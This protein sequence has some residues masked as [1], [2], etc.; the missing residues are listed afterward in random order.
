MV[1]YDRYIEFVLNILDERG[2]VTREDCFSLDSRP[3]IRNLVKEMNKR[4]YS[5][6]EC[7]ETNISENDNI[8][9][10]GAIYDTEQYNMF[11]ARDYLRRYILKKK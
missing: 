1:D 5:N 6:V 10:T 7:I 3:F 8:D 4:G 2:I 11:E 9:Y